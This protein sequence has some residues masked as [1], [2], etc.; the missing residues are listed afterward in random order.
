MTRNVKEVSIG[1]ASP[2]SLAELPHAS[3]SRSLKV[4]RNAFSPVITTMLG[5]RAQ[6]TR[7]RAPAR[8]TGVVAPVWTV[9][10]SGDSLT[11]ARHYARGVPRC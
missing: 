10:A 7:R 9:D 3:E 4:V 11:L 8:T 1:V 5:R 2:R 6:G